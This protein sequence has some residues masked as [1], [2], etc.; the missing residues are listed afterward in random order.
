M[1]DTKQEAKR[2]YEEIQG[3]VK[4]VL[5]GIRNLIEEG[6]ARQLII[7]NKDGEV[8][9]QTQLAFGVGG[10]TLVGA[11]APVVSA[12]G[13]FAMFL[14]DYQILVEKEVSTD[15]HEPEV[16]DVSEESKQETRD[17]D[18]AEIIDITDL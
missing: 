14:N 9:F 4:E 15:E 1:K 18:E 17:S 5:N 7:K 3:G 12:I 6:S 13:M 8:V 10:A 2:I 16:H 11:M